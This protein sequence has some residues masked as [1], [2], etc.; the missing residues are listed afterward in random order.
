MATL[1]S[2]EY[3]ELLF[4]KII[5]MDND[6]FQIILMQS[7][8]TFDRA[9]HDT[10]ADVSADELATAFGYTAGG[11]ALTGSTIT[12]DD[13]ENTVTVTFNNAAWTAAGGSIIAQGAI[14][15]DDTVAAPVADPTVGYIDF[16]GATT[17]L[18]GGVLTVANIEVLL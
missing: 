13:T 4:K 17:T 9:T 8:F 15:F 12:R 6:T 18:D 3:K 16:G 1:P 7:G 2:N 14:I 11:I 10:Y 5:D